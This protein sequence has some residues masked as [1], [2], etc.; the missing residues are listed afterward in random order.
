MRDILATG[1]GWTP[2]NSSAVVRPDA[3]DRELLGDAGGDLA[4]L[5]EGDGV[6]RGDRRVGVDV[7]AEDDRSGWRA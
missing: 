6:E 2:Q 4:D 3:G 1:S 7:L 5:V